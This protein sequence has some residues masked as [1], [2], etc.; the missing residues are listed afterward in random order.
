MTELHVLFD[1]GP[2]V[3]WRDPDTGYWMC[4]CLC[5][6]LFETRDL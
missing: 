4:D 1:P 6:E 5:G 3:A 2:H